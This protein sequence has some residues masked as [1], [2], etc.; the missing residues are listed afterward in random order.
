MGEYYAHHDKEDDKV[1]LA[2]REH[3]QPRYAGDELPFTPE[4]LAVALADKIE[5]LTGLFG[6]GQLPTGEKDP[7]ALRRHALGILRMLIEKE[8]PL[9]LDKLIAIGTEEE[10]VVPG[11]KDATEELKQFF[12]DRLRVMQKDQ[13]FTAHEVE[14]VI[15]SEPAILADVPKRLKAV[16]DFM[17]LPEAESLAAAN[18]RIEN[19][20]KKN[21]LPLADAVDPALLTEKEEKDLYEAIRTLEPKLEADYKAGRY[22]DELRSLA[23]LKAPV[24]AFFDKVMVNAEDEALRRNRLTLLN[25]L[26]KAMNQVAKLSCLAS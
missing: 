6:I 1:A 13:G 18:K 22:E 4:S 7:F 12:H 21:T 8:L 23:P 17:S 16:H 15:G 5:T 9:S 25:E 24:D 14:S 26:H 11:V 2:I 19:I 3:S 20:L 10:S